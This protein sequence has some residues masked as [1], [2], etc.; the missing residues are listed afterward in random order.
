MHR[1]RIAGLLTCAHSA[2]SLSHRLGD[3]LPFRDFDARDWADGSTLG[4]M[5][6][7]LQRCNATA[8][9]YPNGQGSAPIAPNA[10]PSLLMHVREAIPQSIP[11]CEGSRLGFSQGSPVKATDSRDG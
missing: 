9:R 1:F 7:S 5:R 4:A 3:P 11:Y 8:H 2:R 6:P 10:L